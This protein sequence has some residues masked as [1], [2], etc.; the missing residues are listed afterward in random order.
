MLEQATKNIDT[1]PIAENIKF[2]LFIHKV[3]LFLKNYRGTM[4]AHSSPAGWNIS[5]FKLKRNFVRKSSKSYHKTIL[6]VDH[7]RLILNKNLNFVKTNNQ[8][9][10]PL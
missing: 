3:N 2:Q 6:S 8:K 7:F 4:V 1:N 10:L 5:I 9:Y